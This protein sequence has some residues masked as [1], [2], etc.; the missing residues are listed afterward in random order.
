MTKKQSTKPVESALKV[1]KT[2]DVLTHNF[3]TGYS[4][5]ELMKATNQSGAAITRHLKTLIEVGYAEQI[6]DTGR[7]RP[8][9]RYAQHA[10]SIMRSLDKAKQQAEQSLARITRF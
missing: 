1:F 3:A 8:S 4:P 9:H 10:V 6:P 7:Y 5:A 2:L